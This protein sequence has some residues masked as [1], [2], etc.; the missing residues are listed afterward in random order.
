MKNSSQEID[1]PRPQHLQPI[2]ASGEASFSTALQRKY[3]DLFPPTAQVKLK[4]ALHDNG[5]LGENLFSQHKAATRERRSEA[6]RSYSILPFQIK[7]LFFSRNAGD[8]RLNNRLL[9]LLHR[10]PHVYAIDDFLSGTEFENLGH[11]IDQQFGKFRASYTDC[12]VDEQVRNAS[13]T[14]SF[15]SLRKG[16]DSK[17]RAVEN[18]AAEIVGLPPENTEP[19]QI[20]GYRHNDFFDVHHDMGTY[21]KDTGAVEAV[22]PRRL[23][24]FFVYLNSLPRGQ[25]HTV[26]PKLNGGRFSIKPK[27]LRALLWCNVLEDGNPDPRLI[28]RGD[29]IREEGFMKFAINIWITDKNLQ[30][31]AFSNSGVVLDPS[32]VIS[33]KRTIL[34]SIDP[35][36]CI[37]RSH[38][39]QNLFKTCDHCDLSYHR[40]CLSPEERPSAP[41]GPRRFWTC[42]RC[43]EKRPRPG[44]FCEVCGGGDREHLIVLC[45]SCERGFHT[46]CLGVRKVPKEAYFCDSCR[47]KEKVKARTIRVREEGA[48]HMCGSI[49]KPHRILL[50]DG[51]DGGWHL[52]CVGL[53]RV[54][55]GNWFCRLC[56]KTASRRRKDPAKRS[57]KYEPKSNK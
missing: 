50:C 55:R 48:C 12:S 26:F 37:C 27:R 3:E 51:C 22:S 39:Q 14:S 44:D 9:K 29:P 8:I 21:N 4:E 20:V 34:A 40:L 53:A 41:N 25:G 56:T 17:V 57:K 11:L 33:G 7:R 42:P 38:K 10:N 24:T 32:K 47:A 16:G 28:H 49:D 23:V 15:I 5:V 31:L 54:P 46:T 2:P 1:S 18:R 45:D 35:P 30:A 19:L 52:Q 43:P 6:A 36:C 13:R